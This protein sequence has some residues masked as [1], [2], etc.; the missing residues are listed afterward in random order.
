[1]QDDTSV[2][3]K[4]YTPK[5]Q[6]RFALY[7]LL[8]YRKWW[9]LNEVAISVCGKLIAGTPI[10]VEEDALRLVNSRHSYFIPLD[11]IDYIRTTDGLCAGLQ[12]SD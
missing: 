9:E 12:L 4:Q 11:K 7:G 10:F 5:E 3:F 1:M 2:N 8:R 6:A